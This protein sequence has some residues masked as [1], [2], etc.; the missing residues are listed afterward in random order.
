M[1]GIKEDAARPQISQEGVKGF[2]GGIVQ[3]MHPATDMDE[4]IGLTSHQE[5]DFFR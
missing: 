1:I 5:T 3:Q 4:M 2:A